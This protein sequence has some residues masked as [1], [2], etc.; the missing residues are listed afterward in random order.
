MKKT[1][2]DIEFMPFGDKHPPIKV[3]QWYQIINLQSGRD[4]LIAVCAQVSEHDY[5]LITLPHSNRWVDPMPLRS[6][7]KLI[8]D[9]ASKFRL[10][11]VDSVTI[12]IT[13]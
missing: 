6:L 1:K 11:P 12:N 5:C 10:I 13:P 8:N 9:D 7:T 3:G 2:V 4:T